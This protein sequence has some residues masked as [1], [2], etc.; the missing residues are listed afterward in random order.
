MKMEMS[1][2]PTLPTLPAELTTPTNRD[3]SVKGWR[4]RARDDTEHTKALKQFV[5][6]IVNIKS[7]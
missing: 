6:A 2:S 7:S 4:K 5:E 3:A 1:V